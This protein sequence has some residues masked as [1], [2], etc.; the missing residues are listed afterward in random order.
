MSGSLPRPPFGL[1]VQAWCTL[2]TSFSWTLVRLEKCKIPG[3]FQTP[4]FGSWA[5]CTPI[6]WTLHCGQIGPTSKILFPST[7]WLKGEIRRGWK[8]ICNAT[9][10][11]VWWKQPG[12]LCVPFHRGSDMITYIPESP[13]KR[14]ICFLSLQWGF[15]DSSP[16]P[17]SNSAFNISLSQ[18]AL[19][20]KPTTPWIAN[21][22]NAC[23][24]TNLP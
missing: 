22:W 9:W 3:N 20:S 1:Q 21:V 14:A 16:P 8:T 15:R 23:G 2:W 7:C 11:L 18:V 10:C 5:P 24:N 13:E 6:S 12:Y 17:H 4:S 19:G